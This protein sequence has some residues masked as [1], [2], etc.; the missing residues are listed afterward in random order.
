LLG[1]LR[2]TVPEAIETYRDL[3]KKIFSEKSRRLDSRDS[4]FKASNLENAIKSV[5]N[6]K[7]GQ[8]HGED[9]MLDPT[10]GA[11]KV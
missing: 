3:A 6:E 9:M 8:G 1:R 2:L 7:L 4:R 5:L 11:C 10:E